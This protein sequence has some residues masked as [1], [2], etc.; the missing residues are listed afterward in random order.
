MR[1]P[2]LI[3][4]GLALAARGADR[5][6]LFQPLQYSGMAD[7]SG[8][9]AVSSNLFVAADDEKNVLC[10]Y[11]NDFGGAP[12]KQ[13][14]LNLFLGTLGKHAEA[15]LEAGA[16]LGQRAFWIGSHGRSREGEPR[17][18]RCVLF[19]TEIRGEGE[20]VT[21]SPV[22]RPYRGLL[23]DFDHESRLER[24]HLREAA[25]RAPKEPGALNIEGLSATPEGHLLLGFRNPVPEEK[26]LLV[27]LMN[28]DEVI[29]GERARLGE[30]L[31]LDLGGL[32]V[33]D[34]A[35]WQQ[36]YI[37]IAGAFHGGGPF[38]IYRWAG[39][40]KLPERLRVQG[41]KPYHP[42]ALVLYPQLGL[43]QF[44]VLSDDGKQAPSDL[45]NRDLP[46]EQK[47][48]RSFWLRR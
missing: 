36:T 11:R 41:L 9:V 34:I 21:L 20:T 44:Q 30:P 42:E 4:L 3:F 38:H 15:D 25:C 45:S 28:P 37:I 14:D 47:S 32:G 48:F 40:G 6:T 31:L 23:E 1:A 43:E 26:A 17:P 7:A 19:A 22:G 29:A 16:R 5:L 8:A 46:Q 13:F 2:V 33:R 18:N 39:P 12:L 27:P 24:F 10:L 35:L